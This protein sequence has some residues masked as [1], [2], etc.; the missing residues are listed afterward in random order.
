M[1]AATLGSSVDV[2]LGGADLTFPHHAYQAAMVEA[3]TGVT[4]FARAVLHVGEVRC[5][6]AKMA[7]ST[8]NLVLVSDLLRRHPGAV[9]RLAL[10]DRPWQEPWD[11]ADS[12]FDE[13]AGVLERLRSVAGEPVRDRPL[14]HHDGV[15]ARLVDDLDVPGAVALAT[16]EGGPAAAYL[17]DV[18]KLRS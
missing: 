9:L 2:L 17:L 12:V 10:L 18:L 11:C 15:L 4:P 6:G 14:A 1:A 3:A 8:G 13:A 16:E 7:K 5:E